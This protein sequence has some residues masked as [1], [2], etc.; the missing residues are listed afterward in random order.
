VESAGIVAWWLIPGAVVAL[1]TWS[2]ARHRS[3]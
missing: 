3:R 1:L 2:L